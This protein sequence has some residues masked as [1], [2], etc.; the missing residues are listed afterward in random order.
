MAFV[1]ALLIVIAWVVSLLVLLRVA[2]R[3]GWAER[4]KQGII[5]GSAVALAIAGIIHKALR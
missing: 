5:V 4:A 3:K 2:R 1:V